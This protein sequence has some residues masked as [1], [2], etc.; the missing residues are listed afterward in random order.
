MFA[1]IG[2]R[3]R[4]RSPVSPTFQ[5]S[6]SIASRVNERKL[7]ERYDWNSWTERW[8]WDWLEP[9]NKRTWFMIH[10]LIVMFVSVIF[11]AYV[12][13]IYLSIYLYISLYMC[14]CVVA[15]VTV[16]FL[17]VT[18]VSSSGTSWNP[19]TLQKIAARRWSD[20]VG[21]QIERFFLPK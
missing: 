13:C 4:R 6:S 18:Y 1:L 14:V 2:R 9:E 3:E 21:C 7:R 20:K 19:A 10:L 8:N 11:H 15:C 17:F 16:V 5:H 12:Y